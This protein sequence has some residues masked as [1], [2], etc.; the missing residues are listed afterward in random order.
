MCVGLTG[1]QEQ[2]WSDNTGKFS[3]VAE[4]IEVA[5]GKVKLKRVDSGKIVS[6]PLSRLSSQHRALALELQQKKGQQNDEKSTTTSQA[7][8]SVKISGKLKWSLFTPTDEQGNEQPRDLQLVILAKGPQAAEAIK[9]GMVKLDE[10]ETNEG[11]LVTKKERF[12]MNDLSK[13]FA[14]IKRGDN[15]FFAEHPKDA[16]QV[17]FDFEHPDKT[18]K[19]IVAAKGSFRIKTGGQRQTLKIEQAIDQAGK[20]IELDALKEQGVEVSITQEESDLTVTLNGKHES[21]YKV[22]LKDDQGKELKNLN[23]SG[24]GGGGSIM[25]YSF[26]FNGNIPPNTTVYLSMATDLE[27]VE[28]PFEVSKLKIPK[29]PK[30]NSDGVLV[31]VFK[32]AKMLPAFWLPRV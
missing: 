11:E 13:E 22:E 10:I 30:K 8:A 26:N 4:F 31:P 18:I 27:E 29:Q 14:I 17:V 25:S 12:Q 16:V 20:K 28:I 6:V 32:V 19:Q 24:W 5:D 15:E 7:P 3:V 23:G 2:T 1:A 9:Y 21:I